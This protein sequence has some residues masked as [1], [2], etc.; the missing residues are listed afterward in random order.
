MRFNPCST[1]IKKKT[2][3]SS[4]IRKFRWERLQ[5]GSFCISLYI[6]NIRFSFLSVYLS[7]TALV[8]LLLQ[9][10][11]PGLDSALC[12]VH[13]GRHVPEADFRQLHVRPVEDIRVVDAHHAVLVPGRS[14]KGTVSR[15][16]SCLFWTAAGFPIFKRISKSHFQAAKVKYSGEV[17]YLEILDKSLRT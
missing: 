10:L 4:N 3:F 11:E 7:G 13:K 8:D 1:L 2:R 15:D 16:R 12:L 14:F 17:D 9:L 5:S 6:R